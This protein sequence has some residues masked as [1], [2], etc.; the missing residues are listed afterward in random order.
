MNRFL[1]V[2]ILWGSLAV[3]AVCGAVSAVRDCRIKRLRRAVRRAGK[4]LSK[5]SSLVLHMFA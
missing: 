4:T 3:A 5:M 2:W 1:P